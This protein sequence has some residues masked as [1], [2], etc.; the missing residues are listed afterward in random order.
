MSQI[1]GTKAVQRAFDFRQ[2]LAEYG[3]DMKATT[4]EDTT[5]KTAGDM[6]CNH[7]RYVIAEAQ[8][9]IGADGTDPLFQAM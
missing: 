5:H 1:Y 9:E 7:L 4:I 6:Q 3:I 8:Q 2:I